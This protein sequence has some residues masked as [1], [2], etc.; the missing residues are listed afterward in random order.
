MIENKPITEDGR[1]WDIRLSIYA[2]SVVSR[3]EFLQNVS[4]KQYTDGNTQRIKTLQKRIQKTRSQL[5]TC[6]NYEGIL[7]ENNTAERALRNHVVMR[8]IF[9][10]SRSLDGAKAM[11]VNTSVI[12]TFLHQNPDKGFF[13]VI[14]PKL[15]KLHGE[16]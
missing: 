11:E 6:L 8:K 15:K 3:N 12:D 16:E 4:E 10:G 5:L 13:E 14:L 7:P 9:G 1:R 2:I